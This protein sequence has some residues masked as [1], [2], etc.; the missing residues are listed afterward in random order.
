MVHTAQL[1][2]SS[3]NF[4]TFREFLSALWERGDREQFWSI[5]IQ[6]PLVEHLP[7]P[8]A[9]ISNI[10][11]GEGGVPEGRRR[12]DHSS[13]IRGVPGSWVSG[14]G[15]TLSQSICP[16]ETRPQVVLRPGPSA[17]CKCGLPGQPIPEVATSQMPA[18]DVGTR[19]SSA[20]KYVM[21]ASA[22]NVVASDATCTES[23]A[24]QQDPGE[25]T[26]M[27]RAA[28]P[29]S[30]VTVAGQVRDLGQV[31]SAARWTP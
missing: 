10:T 12:G 17:A 13:F 3:Q 1:V 18:L 26:L 31:D 11:V 7:P 8:L 15:E 20:A 25:G 27:R 21:S 30:F 19:Q 23:G 9:P 29:A 2:L 14:S 22:A 16:Q 5:W 6:C 24:A 4:M 28:V